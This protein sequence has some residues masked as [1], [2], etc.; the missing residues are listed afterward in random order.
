MTGET[1]TAFIAMPTSC[2]SLIQSLTSADPAL[3]LVDGR[4]RCEGRVE[5][6]HQGLWGTVCD[7]HW[8]LRNARVVCRLL[9]CG[10]ALGAPGRGRFGPG[11][12]PILLDDVRCAGTEATLGSCAHAG[13][14]KHDCRHHE[15]AGVVCAGTQ[16][17]SAPTAPW[18]VPR[19]CP[20]GRPPR[21][22]HVPEVKLHHPEEWQVWPRPGILQ[23]G[24]TWKCLHHPGLAVDQ[25]TSSLLPTQCIF[26]HRL[27]GSEARG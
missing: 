16:R 11:T 9:R 15:D 18:G 4:S 21:P 25:S 1:Q 24:R 23:K 26:E 27:K 14:A 5:V 8:S 19:P 10:R 3:R 13:W 2:S 6:R 7:D 17:P 22:S 20:L 12:G